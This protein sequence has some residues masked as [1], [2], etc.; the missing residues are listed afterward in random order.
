MTATFMDDRSDAIESVFR[1]RLD[2]WEAR[3]EVD[4]AADVA[5]DEA[6]ERM[7]RA[8]WD[9]IAVRSAGVREPAPWGRLGE[10]TRDTYRDLARAALAA[11][12]E[13]SR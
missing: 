4:I 10:H 6:V 11:M 9:V 12:P 5:E 2:E 13:A 1:A 3:P 7:A 8:M